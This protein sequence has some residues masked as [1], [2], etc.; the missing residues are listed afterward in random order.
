MKMVED[1]I[2][3]IYGVYM[4]ILNQEHCQSLRGE[5][6]GISP[7]SMCLPPGSHCENITQFA[8]CVLNPLLTRRRCYIS[9]SFK[10]KTQ[11]EKLYLQVLIR[12]S[13]RVCRSKEF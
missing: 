10:R 5:R 6:A 1:Q 8:I 9:P 2:I 7:A 3:Y 12:A 11:V 13:G 4:C